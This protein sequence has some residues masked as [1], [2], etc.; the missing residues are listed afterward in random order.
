MIF[1]GEIHS[2]AAFA[3]HSCLMSPP[4]CLSDCRQH[5]ENSKIPLSKRSQY[6]LKRYANGLKRYANGAS[7]VS[8]YCRLSPSYART[9]RPFSLCN[10]RFPSGMGSGKALSVRRRG[11]LPSPLLLTELLRHLVSLQSPLATAIRNSS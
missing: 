4:P 5:R 8:V 9:Y 7:T 10:A 2:V 1:F 11:R 6:G 3:A